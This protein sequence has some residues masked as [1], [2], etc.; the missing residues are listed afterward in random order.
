MVFKPIVNYMCV[1][2]TWMSLT[3]LAM[4]YAVSDEGPKIVE[5]TTLVLIMTNHYQ[6]KL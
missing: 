2:L 5:S 6:C 3:T 1:L 4:T